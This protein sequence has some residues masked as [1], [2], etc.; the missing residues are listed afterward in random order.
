M[1]AW[2]VSF[3]S[4]RLERNLAKELVGPNY[5]AEA[6]MLTFPLDGGGEELRKAPFAYIPNLKDKVIQ[7]LDQNDK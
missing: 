1:K 5:T 2:N 4:E 3:A 7:L 6:V